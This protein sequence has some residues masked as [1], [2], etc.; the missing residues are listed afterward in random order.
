L[1]Q[2][3]YYQLSQKQDIEEVKKAIF[4][5]WQYELNS[6]IAKY[7]KTLEE[8]KVESSENQLSD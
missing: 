3:K 7:E 4:K 8:V 1:E 2:L 5:Q 6:R